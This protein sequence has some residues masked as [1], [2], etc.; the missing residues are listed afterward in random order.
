MEYT[1]P[2]K[3]MQFVLND[4]FNAEKFWQTQADLS[5]IDTDTVNMILEQMAKFSQQV[6]L[7]LNQSGDSEGVTY[8]GDGK[9]KTP[10][11]F[12]QAFQEYADGGWIGLSGD[13]A[14]GGQGMPKMLTMLTDEMMFSTNQSFALYPNLSSG[15]SLCLLA[16]ASDDQKINT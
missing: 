4:V 12:K 8:V 16:S 13:P 6:L 5:H 7:P 9:V 3:E 15:A 11:G 1:A 10:T 2:I 14:Y